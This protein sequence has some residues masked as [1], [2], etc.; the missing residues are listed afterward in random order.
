MP[1]NL[2]PWPYTY[3]RQRADQA[4][5]E[6][7]QQGL[8]PTLANEAVRN[9]HTSG[10]FNIPFLGDYIPDGWEKNGATFFVDITGTATPGDDPILTQQEF[11]TIIGKRGDGVGYGV[12]EHGQFMA[13]IETYKRKE[14]HANQERKD[15]D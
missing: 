4:T 14:A 7:K 9:F 10:R 11:F 12:T 6:A 5:I 15:Q 8:R 3:I 1:K 2:N 13:V